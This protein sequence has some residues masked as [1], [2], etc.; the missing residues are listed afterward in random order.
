MHAKDTRRGCTSKFVL[1]FRG[2]YCTGIVSTHTGT[3]G[4][5]KFR[6]TRLISPGARKELTK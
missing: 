5:W 6:G 2:S 1:Y 4:S 3:D